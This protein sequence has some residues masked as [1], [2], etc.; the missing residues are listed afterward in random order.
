MLVVAFPTPNCYYCTL[1]KKETGYIVSYTSITQIFESS[2]YTFTASSN[3]K[4]HR[5]LQLYAVTR[6]EVRIFYFRRSD[7]KNCDRNVLVLFL[8]LSILLLSVFDKHY[9]KPKHHGIM[10]TLGARHHFGILMR[11]AFRICAIHT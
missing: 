6:F 10:R 5:T 11:P 2:F 8:F 1:G 9:T 3:H 7:K 4:A